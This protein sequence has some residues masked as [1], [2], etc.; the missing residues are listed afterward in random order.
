MGLLSELRRRNV[1][2][3]AVLYLLAAWLIMQVA[4]VVITLGALPNWIGQLILILLAVGSPIALIVSW[5]YELTPEGISLEREVEPHESITH[6]T[7]RRMDFIVISLLCAGLLV[8]AYDKWW[9]SG[10]IDQ[11]IAVLPFQNMSNDSDQDYFSDGV[12]EDLVNMLANIPGLRVTAPASSFQF[13]DQNRDFIEVGEQL[14]VAFILDG[15]VRKAGSQLRITAQLVDASNGFH[16]W[17][18]A[19]NRQLEDML[20]LQNELSEEIVTALMPILDLDSAIP[21]QIS[22]TSTPE[23]Y[24]AYLRGKYLLAQRVPAARENAVQEFRKSISLDPNYAGA[25]AALA[26]ATWGPA[27]NTEATEAAEMHAQRAMKLDPKLAEAHAAIGFTRFLHGEFEAAITDLTTAIE[28]N[29]TFSNAYTWVSFPIFKLGRYSEGMAM[30]E[31]A[32]RVDPLSIPAIGNYAYNLMSQHRFSEAEQEIEKFSTIH[33]AFYEKY[34]AMLSSIDGNWADSVLHGLEALRINPQHNVRE[35]LP[36]YFAAIGLEEEALAI[37]PR[38]RPFVLAMLG[39]PKA[40]LEVALTQVSEQPM[41][42]EARRDL[43]LALAAAGDFEKARPILE[44]M[45]RVSNGQVT[46][47]GQ[48][49]P[50]SAAALIAIRREAGE[51]NTVDELLAAMTDDVRRMREADIR[52]LGL[53]EFVPIN[54]ADFEEGLV[55]YLGGNREIGIALLEKAVDDGFFVLPSEA[56]LQELYVDPLFAPIIAKQKARQARELRKFL[57]VVCVDNPYV[58]VWEPAETTCEKYDGTVTN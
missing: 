8:F 11:S 7:G 45:W 44:E 2:R 41:D 6:I 39:M 29:P 35:R 57:S 14:N 46:F 20:F 22:G 42:Q 40:G 49:L 23:A 53:G 47:W 13:R 28:I 55:A 48:F 38:P 52:V 1:I 4:D 43:G 24:E 26:M 32:K 50:T 54:S 9:P 27:F 31:A 19:Y 21:V 15:S 25:H 16:I 5:F 18:N 33:P 58:R 34:R 10:P 37:H 36:V 3:M 12:S 30:A 56:Y 17:S 51:S